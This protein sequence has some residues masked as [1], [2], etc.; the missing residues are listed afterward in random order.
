MP[1][2]APP[3]TEPRARLAARAALRFSLLGLLG[4]LAAWLGW[5]QALAYLGL[6]LAT[7]AANLAVIRLRNPGLLRERLKADRFTEPF[8][9]TLMTLATPLSLALFAVAGLDVLRFR[10][11]PAPFEVSLLGAALHVTGAI[12]VAWCMAVNPYLERASRVQEERGQT[13]V[14]D[15]PYRYVRHP[16]Y[17]GVMLMLAGWPLLLGSYWACGPAALLAVIIVL[18]TAY[19]DRMLRRGLPA[20]EQYSRRTRFRLLPGVW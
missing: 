1:E 19:E 11:S 20:Y 13:V 18:R 14:T 12:P 6:M 5:T 16:M 2:P 10:W 17:A 3:E 4:I 8:D 15:G 9:R 7:L